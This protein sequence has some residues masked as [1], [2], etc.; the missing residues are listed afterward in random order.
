MFPNLT[1][2]FLQ[3]LWMTAAALFHLRTFLLTSQDL[4]AA[5]DI[6]T[7]QALHFIQV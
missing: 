4:T 6:K 3:A 1:L 2:H 5:G 7:L